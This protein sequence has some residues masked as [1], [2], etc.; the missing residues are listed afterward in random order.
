MQH[1]HLAKQVSSLTCKWFKKPENPC[2]LVHDEA[3]AVSKFPILHMPLDNLRH[4]IFTNCNLFA[5]FMWS[6]WAKGCNLCDRR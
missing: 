2:R 6:T 1:T 5:V 3:H 4:K